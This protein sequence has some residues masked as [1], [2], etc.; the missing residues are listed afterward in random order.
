M[1]WKRKTQAPSIK[2]SPL[3]TRW[4]SPLGKIVAVHKVYIEPSKPTLLHV[5][6]PSKL[7]LAIDFTKPFLFLVYQRPSI[8]A[9]MESPLMRI[10]FRLWLLKFPFSFTHSQ[11]C[12]CGW[13]MYLQN[14]YQWNERDGKER[15][16]TW[17]FSKKKLSLFIQRIGFTLLTPLGFLGYSQYLSE[18]FCHASQLC[19]CAGRRIVV[20][21]FSKIWRSCSSQHVRPLRSW[22]GCK[23]HV[24]TFK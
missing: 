6:K 19:V 18:A 8:K 3:T 2:T 22:N 16:R 17:L 7:Q 15:W 13:G 4:K 1:L 10:G 23:V 20:G 21:T 12:V 5:L 11:V 9:P 14:L 24:C